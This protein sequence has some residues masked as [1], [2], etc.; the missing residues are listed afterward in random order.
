MG[1]KYKNKMIWYPECISY[2]WI[3]VVF[4]VHETSQ[5]RCNCITHTIV[6]WKRYNRH[7]ILTKFDTVE[8]WAQCVGLLCSHALWLLESWESGFHHTSKVILLNAMAAVLSVL[9]SKFTSRRFTPCTTYH[10]TSAVTTRV[11]WYALEYS[12][13]NDAHASKWKS[14][15]QSERFWSH[16]RRSALSCFMKINGYRY[17]YISISVH[18]HASVLSIV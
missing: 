4:K 18:R 2:R 10:G 8:S 14:E 3:S 16:A 11:P 12:S 7:R 15:K 5:T 17:R 1:Y 13:S 6:L 9:R